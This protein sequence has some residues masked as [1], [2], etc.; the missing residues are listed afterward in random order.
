MMTF[1]VRY[2]SGA[3][4]VKELKVIDQKW[5]D[6]YVRQFRQDPSVERVLVEVQ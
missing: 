5:M 6:F 3:T 4:F 1:H 2:K